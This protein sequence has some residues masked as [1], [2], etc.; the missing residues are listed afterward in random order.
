MKHKSEAQERSTSHTLSQA[1]DARELL[2]L[3]K[4]LF[5]AFNFFLVAFVDMHL[6]I[7]KELGVLLFKFIP[8]CGHLSFLSLLHFLSEG[9]LAGLNLLDLRLIARLKL[10]D[11]L[12]LCFLQTQNLFLL[13]ALQ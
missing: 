2:V 1:Y 7:G 10:L 12:F 11:F 6:V 8:Q 3:C 5:Q 13:I 9:E 4:L